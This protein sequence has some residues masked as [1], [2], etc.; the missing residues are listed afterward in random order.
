MIIKVNSP[1]TIAVAAMRLMII[2]HMR[3]RF[4]LSSHLK[5]GYSSAAKRIEKETATSIDFIAS[6]PY[7]I[8]L[9][10][11]RAPAI[12]DR[13]LVL[14]SLAIIARLFSRIVC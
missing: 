9:M 7:T 8:R 4:H 6:M 1:P 10:M 3:P 2:V 11:I 13:R 14:F 12:R 5:S